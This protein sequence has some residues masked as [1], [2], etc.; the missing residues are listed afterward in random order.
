VEHKGVLPDGYVAA[1]PA[2]AAYG[3]VYEGNVAC[4]R[5]SS[6]RALRR[7][8]RMQACSRLP[9]SASGWIMLRAAAAIAAKARRLR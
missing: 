8:A 4:A 3:R 6:S 7:K 1:Y 5:S 2:A 9:V